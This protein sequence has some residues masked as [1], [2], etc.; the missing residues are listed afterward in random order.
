MMDRRKKWLYIGVAAIIFFVVVLI[1]SIVVTSMYPNPE[2]REAGL[3]G[4][5]YHNGCQFTAVRCVLGKASGQDTEY[6]QMCLWVYMEIEN[7]SDMDSTIMGENYNIE[8]GCR[9][10]TAMDPY[11]YVGMNPGQT[12]TVVTL[13]PGEKLDVILPFRVSRT[14]MTESTWDELENGEWYFNVSISTY[15]VKNVFHFEGED[16]TMG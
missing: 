1:R 7:T 8:S 11:E 6:E 5:L 13:G 9:F 16:I 12:G 10:R 3:G 15:P 14:E 4:T 2:V